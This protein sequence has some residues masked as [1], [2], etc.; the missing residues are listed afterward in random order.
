MSAL[1]WDL[2]LNSKAILFTCDT[3]QKGISSRP[4]GPHRAELGSSQSGSE[5]QHASPV[6]LTAR[7]LSTAVFSSSELKA[8]RAIQ[9]ASARTPSVHDVSPI[10]L[11]PSSHVG[12]H[13]SP[14]ARVPAHVPT[15][16]FEGGVDAGHAAALRYTSAPPLFCKIVSVRALVFE[17]PPYMK[18][19]PASTV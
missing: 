14:L 18:T 2:Y 3:S 16:P 11:N 8:P 13:D 9:L 6:E 19:F 12:T 4:A 10:S 17:F 5:A 15:A 1:N 7:H